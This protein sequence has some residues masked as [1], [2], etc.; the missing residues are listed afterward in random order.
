MSQSNDS[1]VAVELRPF[2]RQVGGHTCVLEVSR[3]VICKPYI[4]KEVWFYEHEP[5]IVKDFTPKYL[6]EV[7][8]TCDIT[9]ERKCPI[10]K[11]PKVVAEEYGI[12]ESYHP[13]KTQ[14]K[15]GSGS[16][17]RTKRA[18]NTDKDDN[19]INGLS[20]DAWSQRCIERQIRQ[21]GFWANNQPQKFIMLE[22]LVCDYEHPC[23]MDLKMGR[24]QYG[25]DSDAEKRK[26][27]ISRCDQT[28]SSK[29]GF[30]ICG[31]Q[32]YQMPSDSYTVHDKYVGRDLDTAGARKE[33]LMFFDNGKFLRTDVM[34]A[35]V[36]KLKELKNVI[37][38]Q[39]TLLFHSASLL[40]LY[41]G[42]CCTSTEKQICDR[43]T[44]TD[45]SDISCHDDAPSNDVGNGNIDMTNGVQ[46][47]DTV[48]SQR[49]RPRFD[50]RLIDFAHVTKTAADEEFT[51]ADDTIVFGLEKVREILKELVNEKQNG[52]DLI[53]VD[54]ENV[55]DVTKLSDM[56]HA[57]M[58]N[59]V[60]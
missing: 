52:V 14:T 2:K 19:T 46:A 41:D 3:S 38:M 17:K 35:I 45:E 60:D 55:A 51:I 13:S 56:L 15:Y 54:L 9:Q 21:Y 47:V 16:K 44:N 24:Q 57:D 59:C 1:Y 37:A 8:V 34:Q 48:A 7:E 30:R 39:T 28:T 6:G 36:C 50:V 12:T 20:L 26:L 27:L 4:D 58:G 5:D 23:L 22:N 40:L 31:S 43:Q 53:N 42:A 11:V 18:S 29:L 49:I 25:E 32:T 33:L 10:A